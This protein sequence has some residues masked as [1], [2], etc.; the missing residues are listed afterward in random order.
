M[1][2]RY[3]RTIDTL[4]DKLRA[5]EASHAEAMSEC[6][7]RARQSGIAAISPEPG[8][9]YP[10]VRSVDAAPALDQL[11]K[12]KSIVMTLNEAK[13]EGKWMPYFPFV[14]SIRSKDDL[15]NFMNGDALLMVLLETR[16]SSRH[17]RPGA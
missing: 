7:A 9:T 3:R 14:L 12:P 10:C 16:Q 11:V 2:N 4:V 17:L 15:Y 5:L 13:T 6:I 1:L 8:L